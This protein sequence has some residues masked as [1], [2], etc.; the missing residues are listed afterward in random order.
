MKLSSITSLLF[1]AV[2]AS[3][4]SASGASIRGAQHEAGNERAN[5]TPQRQLMMSTNSGTSAPYVPQTLSPVAPITPT[6]NHD[7]VLEDRDGG[8]GMP[9]VKPAKETR[10]IMVV[11]NYVDANP[12]SI[13][14]QLLN[15]NTN[16]YI[17]SS[18]LGDVTHPGVVATPK[19]QVPTG[20]YEFIMNNIQ[21][22]GLAQGAGWVKIL[23]VTGLSTQE[24][25]NLEFVVSNGNVVFSHNGRFGPMLIEDFQLY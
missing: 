7:E 13:S 25:A 2:F 20:P 10:D 15:L 22:T 16:R 19:D 8:D 23:D 3:T 6:Y 5:A 14:W 17:M 9:I 24:R 1:I 4:E 11:V 12:E 18:K 21:G